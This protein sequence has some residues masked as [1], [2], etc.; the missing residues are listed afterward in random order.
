MKKLIQFNATFITE[1]FFPQYK[2]APEVI[3]YGECFKWGYLAYMVFEGVELWDTHGHAFV[4]YKGKFYDSD[5]P[6]GVLDYRELP[7]VDWC[8]CKFCWAGAKKQTLT[9][10]KREWKGACFRYASNWK[11]LEKQAERIVRQSNAPNT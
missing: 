2:N 1:T 3:N 4:K 7:A 8:R 10:F 11:Q 5:R 9:S 6:L